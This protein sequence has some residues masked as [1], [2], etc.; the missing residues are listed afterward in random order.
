V[1][2]SKV[3]ELGWEDI[4]SAIDEYLADRGY[5]TTGVLR[6]FDGNQQVHVSDMRVEVEKSAALA[7]TTD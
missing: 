1:K 2:E 6:C 5:T 4:E 3:V 7:E